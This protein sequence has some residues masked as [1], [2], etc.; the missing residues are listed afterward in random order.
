MRKNKGV[1]LMSKKVYE[2]TARRIR[3]EVGRTMVVAESEK[4]AA[5]QMRG[6]LHK[7]EYE[8]DCTTHEIDLVEEVEDLT[9]EEVE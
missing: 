6:S 5:S 8:Y 3:N 7:I 9:P 2:I 4:E 1:G